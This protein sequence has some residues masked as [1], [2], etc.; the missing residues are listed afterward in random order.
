[1]K[2]LT[3]LV[4]AAVARNALLEVIENMTADLRLSLMRE[5]LCAAA[6]PLALTQ[7]ESDEE[8]LVFYKQAKLGFGLLVGY[9]DECWWGGFVLLTDD[10]ESPTSELTASV[11][12]HLHEKGVKVALK[13]E[14]YAYV[15]LCECEEFGEFLSQVLEKIQANAPL[16]EKLNDALKDFK[17][18]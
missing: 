5:V 14:H 17:L 18:S 7:C 4:G 16:L 1:M 12:E 15:E 10:I 9:Y 6:A 13:S 3:N 2:D 11:Q 8:S